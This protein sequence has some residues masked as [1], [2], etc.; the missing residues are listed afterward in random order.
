M[1]HVPHNH[2]TFLFRTAKGPVMIGRR[3]HLSPPTVRD[4]VRAMGGVGHVVI[5]H[6]GPAMFGKPAPVLRLFNEKI[7]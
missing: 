2:T 7:S 4:L 5:R 6:H 1:P 3:G